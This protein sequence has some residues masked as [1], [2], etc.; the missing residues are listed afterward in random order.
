MCVSAFVAVF[1]TFLLVCGA[2]GRR[3][4]DLGWGS[5]E[6]APSGAFWPPLGGQRGSKLGP[7]RGPSWSQVAIK[8]TFEVA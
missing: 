6:D 2:F 7:S 3:S 4:L 5:S 8:I 1:G